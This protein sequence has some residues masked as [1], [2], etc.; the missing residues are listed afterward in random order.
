M[1]LP[2]RKVVFQSSIFRGYASFREGIFHQIFFVFFAT[3]KWL[4]GPLH[5]PPIQ[6]RVLVDWPHRGWSAKSPARKTSETNS[7]GWWNHTPHTQRNYTPTIYATTYYI[8]TL[9]LPLHHVIFFVVFLFLFWLFACSM[10]LILPRLG[11]K[12]I[13]LGWQE[14]TFTVTVSSLL[15]PTKKI[16]RWR[17]FGNCLFLGGGVI[18]VSKNSGTPKWMV[19]N[20]KPY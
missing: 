2:K 11:K 18:G 10:V 5:P 20:G 16:I 7:L 15:L 13:T 8:Y 6:H 17:I 12:K 14:G 3:T 19:Y 1:G 4:K 9:C